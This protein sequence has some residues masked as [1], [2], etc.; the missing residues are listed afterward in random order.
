MHAWGVCDRM[1]KQLVTFEIMAKVLS[2]PSLQTRSS[3][4]LRK[5]T[6]ETTLEP[7]VNISVPY[8]GLS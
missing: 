4:I 6:G 8:I 1:T 7:R 2:L 3:K 5:S